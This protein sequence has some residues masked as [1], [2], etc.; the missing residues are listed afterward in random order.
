MAAREFF[1]GLT[2]QL[3]FAQRRSITAQEIQDQESPRW[4][5]VR[6][7]LCFCS[8]ARLIAHADA[9]FVD[10]RMSEHIG[11]GKRV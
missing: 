7:V 5:P 9:G 1:G 6:Q 8:N 3:T 4:S 2:P 10:A 11:D